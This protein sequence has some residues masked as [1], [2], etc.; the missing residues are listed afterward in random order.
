MQK[1]T[2]FLLPLFFGAIAGCMV[3]T[4]LAVCVF[5]V[6]L[7]ASPPALESG[8]DWSIAVG[9]SAVPTP[10]GLMSVSPTA[11]PQI[12]MPSGT[13]APTSV[14]SPLVPPRRAD[15]PLCR[16]AQPALLTDQQVR[17]FPA[18][19]E[20]APRVAYRDPV[21][22][23]CVVRVTDHLKDFSPSK[24]RGLKNEYSR[25]QAF[26][27]D[28]SRLIARG[29]DGS[30]YLYDAATLSPLRELPIQVDPRWDARDPTKLY[31]T[32]FADGDKSARL[33]AFNVESLAAS[34]EHDFGPDFPGQKIQAA[35][36]RYDGSPSPDGRYWGLLAQNEEW[37]TVAFLIYD[38][39]EGRV[40]AKRD[41]RGI[42][43][44]DSVDNAHVSPLGTYFIADFADHYCERGTLGTDAHPCGLMVYDRE[45]K[46]GRGVLRTVGHADLALDAQGR[47]VLV[48]QDVD[49]DNISMV[50][51]ATGMVTPLLPIDFSH[52]AIG[53]HISGRA[54]QR[55][56]WAV[57]STYNG[58][59]PTAFTWMDNQ[60][61]LVE[62]KK[63]GRVVRL[64]PTRG[65]VK[66]G[67][68]SYGEKDYWAE[69]HASANQDLTRIVFTSNWGRAGTEE[70]DM[71]MIELP[72]DWDRRLP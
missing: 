27:A 34:V 26:N 7:R 32:A 54:F 60:V 64:T 38:Q 20:P 67:Q 29:T 66:E 5:V 44:A 37:Q 3:V 51:F 15:S 30:W 42:P 23:G 11:E 35:W 45:L 61:F 69:A 57:V 17:Q 4:L 1:S 21:L 55:P 46:N 12:G 56:G 62:V 18:L 65:V 48:F 68:V 41:M 70:V 6:L 47:E 50:D 25:V 49:T 24:P 13:P 19:A 33:M 22:G 40:I 9:S 28:G 39:R 10:L 31:F 36:L 71:Y 16:D 53:F 72:P 2:N 59:Y 63:G 52:T 8:V 14:A 43:G 58:G